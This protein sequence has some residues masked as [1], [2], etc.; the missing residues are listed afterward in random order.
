VQIPLA[1]KG[2]LCIELLPAKSK[3]TLA[4]CLAAKEVATRKV[5]TVVALLIPSTTTPL[6]GGGGSERHPSTCQ[7]ETPV[8]FYGRPT[9]RSQAHSILLIAGA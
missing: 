1:G 9:C 7:T 4:L 2:R 5:F 6:E 3:A 8:L